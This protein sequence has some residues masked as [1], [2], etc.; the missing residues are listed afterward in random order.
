MKYGD[1]AWTAVDPASDHWMVLGGLRS[2]AA[3]AWFPYLL[4][5][6]AIGMVSTLRMPKIGTTGRPFVDAFQ[7][8][9]LFLGYLVG[10]AHRMPEYFVFAASI[11]FAVTLWYHRT[12]EVARSAKL[13]PLFGS[14]R[15]TNT[16]RP[17]PEIASPPPLDHTLARSISKTGTDG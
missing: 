5:P 1:P 15:F 9:N 2:D 8:G 6:G 10:L 17:I 7:F 3:L 12:N 4:I 16:T 11:Y 14:D 13:P